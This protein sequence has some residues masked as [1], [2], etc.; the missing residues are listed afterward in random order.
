MGYRPEERIRV[1]WKFRNWT[2]NV[3]GI[4]GL[5]GELV[6]KNQSANKKIQIQ[7]S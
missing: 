7:N 5:D 1:K 3:E 2:K 4:I 6:S